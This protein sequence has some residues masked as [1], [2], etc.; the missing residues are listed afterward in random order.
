MSR[1]F[2]H[3]PVM[4]HEVV[5]LLAPVP[6][7]LV[8]D[9][10]LGAAGHARALLTAR[11]HLSLLGVDRDPA[12]LEA[13]RREL[14]DF[15]GRAELHHATFDRLGDL[16]AGRAASAFLFDLG[17]ASPQLDRAERGFS[18]SREGPLDMRMD[19]SQ[20]WSAADLVNGASAEELARLFAEHGEARSARRIAQAI[21]AARPI[22]TTTDLTAV[23]DRSLPRSGRR[24]GHPASRVFQALR[25][26]VND[27]QAQLSS[28]L[29]VALGSLV[30]GGRCVVISYHSG[31]DRL[32]KARFVEAATGS[33]TCPPGLPCVCGAEP[34]VRLITRGARKPSPAEVAANPRA[35][36]ARLRAVE[37]LAGPSDVGVGNDR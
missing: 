8:V 35:R 4:T 36:S 9:A 17:V 6:A 1:P 29:D 27:E 19:P 32:V 3:E 25:S 16:L 30:T 13:A 5:A 34:S 21:V 23:V 28:G 7:G 12:A 24:R 14:A 31:E 22:T 11:P 33:C 10:T 18:Y 15:S 26:E 37:Q 20:A 2:A